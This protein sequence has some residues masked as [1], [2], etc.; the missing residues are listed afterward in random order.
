M[1]YYALIMLGGSLAC[2]GMASLSQKG[3]TASVILA[4]AG[5]LFMAMAIGL[6]L[7]AIGGR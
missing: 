1:A 4:L 2:L 7:T 3:S 6:G 5:A